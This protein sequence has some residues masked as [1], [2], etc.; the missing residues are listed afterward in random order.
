MQ[1]SEISSFN[2]VAKAVLPSSFKDIA[3][4]SFPCLNL[5]DE[6]STDPECNIGIEVM[7]VFFA[8]AWLGFPIL[9]SL[10]K[11]VFFHLDVFTQ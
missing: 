4:Q 3:N 7:L 11:L 10:L 8:D 2:G 6:G 1:D 9:L 5:S